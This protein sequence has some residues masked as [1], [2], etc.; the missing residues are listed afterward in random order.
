MSWLV[1]AA[2]EEKAIAERRNSREIIVK[3]DGRRMEK[4]ERTK[5]G[6]SIYDLVRFEIAQLSVCPRPLVWAA[7]SERAVSDQIKARAP[8]TRITSNDM[9]H[10]AWIC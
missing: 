6:G 3:R 8:I 7:N 4:R 5:N 10:E 2:T 1:W 9:I